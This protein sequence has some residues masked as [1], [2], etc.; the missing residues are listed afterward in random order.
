ML[1]S[2]VEAVTRWCAIC[3]LF[4]PTSFGIS[5]KATKWRLSQRQ[6][7]QGANS[8]SLLCAGILGVFCSAST[9]PAYSLVAKWH[10]SMGR[11][12]V[13]TKASEKQIFN[14]SALQNPTKAVLR[15]VKYLGAFLTCCP[16]G[17]PVF[18]SVSQQVWVSGHMLQMRMEQ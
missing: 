4:L 5:V 3:P 15:V 18:C 11:F 8:S 6:I 7:C 13:H 17:F 2:W 1:K 14:W 12:M 16:G 10:L 9:N